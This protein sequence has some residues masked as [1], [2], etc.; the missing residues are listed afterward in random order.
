MCIS[1]VG[2]KKR[3]PY[4]NPF[5]KPISLPQQ[6]D[7]TT[8]FSLSGK[9]DSIQLLLIADLKWCIFPFKFFVASMFQLYPGYP[10]TWTPMSRYLNTFVVVCAIVK[11]R[12]KSCCD[13]CWRSNAAYWLTYSCSKK[14]LGMTCK[15]GILESRLQNQTLRSCE[16]SDLC[17]FFCVCN[18]CRNID[19]A[20]VIWSYPSHLNWLTVTLKD[21]WHGHG[22]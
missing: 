17:Y 13:L 11:L 6:P 2:G 19:L 5:L 10:R 12:I 9:K 3:G 20:T 4:C 1:W 7:I 15:K 16:M 18:W 21:V 22:I 14:T 8:T